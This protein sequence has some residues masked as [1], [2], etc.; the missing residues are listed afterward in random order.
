[1]EYKES[2]NSSN[3]RTEKSSCIST[4]TGPILASVDG[5]DATGKKKKNKKRKGKEVGESGI[6][7]LS[8]NLS[9]VTKSNND[10]G[11]KSPKTTFDLKKLG[12][13][14]QNSESKAQEGKGEKQHGKKKKQKLKAE[15]STEGSNKLEKL[16]TNEKPNRKENKEMT[17]KERMTNQLKAARFRYLNEKL[18]TQSGDLAMEM[19]KKDRESYLVYHEGFQT[20]VAKWPT[21]PVD[22]IIEEL[23]KC[24]QRTVI[25]D[26][27]CGDAKIARSLPL[28]V[29]SFDLVAINKY[30]T[31]CNMAKVPL[32]NSTVDVAV[33]CLSL[34]GTN[35]KDYLTEANRVLKKNGTMKVAEV[36]SRFNSVPRF[37]LTV[38]KFGF[39][40]TSQDDSNKMFIMLNF[41]KTGLPKTGAPDFKLHPCVYKKR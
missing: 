12:E 15:N 23:K 30:V 20:Q 31:A 25:A 39:K 35:L 17:L 13:I 28:K 29:H 41:K 5:V 6:T 19:F 21:N 37:L 24:N 34:M 10:L 40:L 22:V 36:S 9:A 7:H 11:K 32:S 3:D 38:E 8:D 16:S 27:G 26:F 14:L 18:Y 2:K 33:F 4:N 1:M